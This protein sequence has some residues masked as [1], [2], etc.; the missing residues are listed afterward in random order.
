MKQPELGKKISDLRKQKGLTQEDLV[1]RC[2]INVRTI[3]RIEAGEVS[4]RSYT[5]KTILKALDYDY[6]DIHLEDIEKISF[7]NKEYTFLN[8]AFW[9]GI[10]FVLIDSFNLFLN[11]ALE[12]EV[13]VFENPTLFKSVYLVTQ[14]I[15][16]ILVVSFYSGFYFTGKIF[17]NSLL[18]VTAILMLVVSI[19]H[20]FFSAFLMDS[21]SFI[22]TTYAV[23]SLLFYGAVG[24]PFGIGILKLQKHLGQY[25]TITGIFTIILYVC[26]LTVILVFMVL[27]LWLPVMVLQLIL[28]YKIREYVLKANNHE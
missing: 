1:E 24:I 10:L 22:V 13:S 11:F 23:T 7:S 5:L 2:N 28:L 19:C 26:M 17:K 15:S 6:G 20:Y 8:L 16:V 25:S 9:I 18:K 27:F 3:Q 14:I 12:F 4:P 21:N